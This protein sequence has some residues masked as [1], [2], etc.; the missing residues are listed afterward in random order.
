MSRHT[1]PLP[2]MR[3]DGVRVDPDVAVIDERM[4]ALTAAWDRWLAGDARALAEF[5]RQ[6][7]IES[8]IERD[9][10]AFA[11][12]NEPDARLAPRPGT[13]AMLLHLDILRATNRSGKS[14]SQIVRIV[15]ERAGVTV[16]AVELADKRRRDNRDA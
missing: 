7:G 10:I 5:V 11:L 1:T 8:Q 6:H 9:A 15:A 2:P 12:T 4:T 16:R 13:E 14:A 3:V